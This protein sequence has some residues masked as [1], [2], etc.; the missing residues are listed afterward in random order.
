[1]L[2]VNLALI[3]GLS[4]PC[5]ATNRPFTFE[6]K[7][8]VETFQE[9]SVNDTF[10]NTI[11]AGLLEDKSP[12]FNLATRMNSFLL[13][14]PQL[15]HDLPMHY[16][17]LKVLPTFLCFGSVGGHSCLIQLPHADYETGV[18][19]VTS[20]GRSKTAKLVEPKSDFLFV[21][22]PELTVLK[23]FE[24]VKNSVYTQ[25]EKFD[26]RFN[27]TLLKQFIE[28]QL[29]IHAFLVNKGY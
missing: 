16:H 1:M 4:D 24:D 28:D 5:L 21:L 13:E 10:E 2:I 17:A 27:A 14:N 6:I 12:I 25:R 29:S 8:K 11:S 18:Y 20:K 23:D 15:E 7:T 9:L 26:I 19:K 3:Q 22:P